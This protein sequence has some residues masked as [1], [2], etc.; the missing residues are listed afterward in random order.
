MAQSDSQSKPPFSKAPR[1]LG[2]GLV[3]RWSTQ[4][5]IERIA[6]LCSVVFRNKLDDPPNTRIATWMRDLGSGRHPLTT[7]DQG[8]FVEDTRTGKAVASM[9]L[10]PTSW[11]FDGIRFGVGRPEAVASHPDY[12]RRGLVRALFEAF[13]ARS[14][15]AGDLVQGITGIPYYYRQFGYEMALELEGGRY[16]LFEDI[17]KLKEGETER[18]RLQTATADD[19]PFVMDLY[20]RDRR[21]SLVSADIPDA[22][23]RWVMDGVDPASGEGWTTLLIV[24]AAGQP[25][26]FTLTSP[27]RWGNTLNIRQMVLAEGI[28]WSAALHPVLRALR[29]HARAVPVA[30]EPAEDP[31]RLFFNFGTAHP[32]YAVLGESLAPRRERPYAWYVR[33]PDLPGFLR[34]I[35]PALEARLRGSPLAGYSGE[36]RLDFYRGGLRL[37]F[38]DGRIA[39]VEPWQRW[40]R[41]TSAEDPGAAFPPLVF[42]QLVFGRRSRAELQYVLPDVWANEE[43][44]ALLDVL[45]PPRS[46]HVITLD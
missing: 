12:R 2:D 8:V 30:R 16:V 34:R 9:W 39:T 44:E 3:L 19:L 29:D 38:A 14:A 22:Y 37:V 7:V 33:V 42:L 43:A 17:P 15:H 5:D 23:W 6:E 40:P 4:D 1:D 35:A 13:H 18:Y 21:R 46:S 24:D 32:I 25:C 36:L 20:E 41:P 26:G 10:I 45:F 11:T 31:N 28:P 27:R